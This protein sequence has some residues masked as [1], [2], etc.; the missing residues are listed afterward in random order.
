MLTA[1]DIMRDAGGEILA[2]NGKVA[3][4]HASVDSRT[5]RPGDLFF[6]L[7]GQRVDGHQFVQDAFARGALGVVVREGFAPVPAGRVVVRV[8]DPAIALRRVAAA[9][10]QR[11]HVQV[12][13]VT[14]S[15]GK[16]TTKELTAAVL[17]TEGD[18]LRS[19]GNHNT[20]IGL[21]LALVD[22]QPNHWA[23]VLEMGMRG[24]GEIRSLC[25]IARPHVGIVTGISP[26]HLEVMGTLEAIAEAKAELVEALPADGT[27]VIP[28][29]EA[30]GPYLELHTEAN[31]VRVGPGGQL[32][33]ED[34]KSRGLE[35]VDFVLTDGE[36]RERVH[37]A[38][39]GVH[40]V[41][42]ALLAAAAG[43]SLG[44][45]L[46]QCA[47]GLELAPPEGARMRVNPGPYTVLDDSY[48]ASPSSMQA[49]LRLLGSLP[50]RRVA[51]LGEM[52]ELGPQS[53]RFHR[54]LGEQARSMDALVAI[55]PQADTVRAG[56]E[57]AGMDPQ[58]IHTFPTNQAA[59]AAT[60]AWARP[61]DTILVKG[62]RGSALDEVVQAL[63][64]ETAT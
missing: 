41:K 59:L 29:D 3:F 53:D 52:L 33:A 11:S 21:P 22:L 48:N 1:E 57:A 8:E 18:T 24:P 12:V 14:G 5:C 15:V 10:R 36:R 37:L 56:A 23:A 64:R 42:N 58:R 55:G 63:V 6:A 54:E 60:A 62:S 20:E 43:I 2:G 27:A 19:P 45:K 4:E 50:G 38:W 35:G 30:F 25:R 31:V 32:W 40:L 47:R 7:K 34:V 28:V 39:V 46:G 9:R 26:V 49:A 16:S 44:L 13:G 17:G 51:V 61:G